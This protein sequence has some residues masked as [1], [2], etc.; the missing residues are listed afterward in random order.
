VSARL[1]IVVGLVIA[2]VVAKG[3]YRR[4]QAMV[5]A[6]DRQVPKLPAQLVGGGPSTWVVFTTRYCASCE[7]VCQRLRVFYPD[8]VVVK[9]DAADRPELARAFRIQ[10]AP[11]A[12]LADA[13]GAVTVRLVG[14]EGV[15]DYLRARAHS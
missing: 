11:T 1:D 5:R 7:P 8:A 4:R 6:D 12:L 10:R 14:P 15:D 3:L 2:L 9:V 13:D